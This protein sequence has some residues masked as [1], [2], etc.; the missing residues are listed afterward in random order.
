MGR[1]SGW[2][3]EN[4]LNCTVFSAATSQPSDCMAK[5]A[6]LLP[7]LLQALVGRLLSSLELRAVTHPETTLGRCQQ[8]KNRS[9]FRI[10]GSPT[11]LATARTRVSGTR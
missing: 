10:V 7:T 2:K 8:A 6:I 11:W 4:E 3:A 1:L 5:T 9:R